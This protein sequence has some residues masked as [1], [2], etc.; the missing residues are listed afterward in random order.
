MGK[1]NEVTLSFSSEIM[2]GFDFRDCL[3][4]S[5]TQICGELKRNS[6]FSNP[7]VLRCLAASKA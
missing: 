1:L 2:V 7:I 5:D 4:I 6:K 3:G